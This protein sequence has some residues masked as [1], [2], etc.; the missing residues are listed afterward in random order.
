LIS[1]SK[2]P[3]VKRAEQVGFPFFYLP[4]PRR[5]QEL[6]RRVTSALLDECGFDICLSY[7][8]QEKLDSREPW[9]L[10]IGDVSNE[11]HK[12]CIFEELDRTE[13]IFKNV[14]HLYVDHNRFFELPL[15]A[16]RFEKLEF[17]DIRGC[18]CWDLAMSQ[19]PQTVKTLKFIDQ[20][21]L[22]QECVNGMDGLVR[23]Q[24]LYLDFDTFNLL[25]IFHQE[26]QVRCNL[27][28][29]PNVPLAN[30][31]TLQSIHLIGIS[32]DP[33]ETFVEDWPKRIREVDLFA[34]IRGRIRDVC[35][36][37]SNDIVINLNT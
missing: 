24:H 6:K 12:P 23:L 27:T 4:L 13:N 8:S 19:V 29:T 35:I 36:N 22:S 15:T 9:L 1:I 5:M 32:D 11:I 33:E 14:T 18:R 2:S 17:V 3:L 20:T 37:D 21:N 30:V 25:S 31:S 26:Y 10:E 16:K 34:N 28:T 7:E